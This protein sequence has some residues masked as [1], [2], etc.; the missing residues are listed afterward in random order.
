M[1]GARRWSDPATWGGTRTPQ[2]NEIVVIPAGKA[3]LL[4]VDSPPL[5]GLQIDG[6]LYV[7]DGRDLRL[8]AGWVLVQGLLRAG[9]PQAGHQSRFTLTLTGSDEAVNLRGYGNKFLGV[10][11][12]GLI[13]LHGARRDSLAWAK[14]AAHAAPGDMHIALN[15]APDWR[16]GDELVI[17]PSGYDPREAERV[18]VTAVNGSEVR[19][20]PALRHAHW[21]ELQRYEGRTLDA[22]AAVG[23]LT[24]N[25]VIEGDAASE[26]SQFGG[27]MMVHA[28]GF[29]R[30]TGVSFRRMGQMGH[31]ARYPLHW[32]LVDRRAGDSPVR[33]AGQYA[34]GNSF[35]DSFQRAIVV[36]G[37]N[38]V[39]AERNVAFNVH[40]HIFVPA[41]DGDEENNIFR[42]NLGVLARPPL[43]AY[44]AFAPPQRFLGPMGG[45]TLQMEFQPSVFWSRNVNHSFI[46]NIAAGAAGGHGFLFDSFFRYDPAEPD[47]TFALF[48]HQKP[49]RAIVFEDNVAH[50]IC[51]INT[52]DQP[53][54]WRAPLGRFGN[55]TYAGASASHGLALFS[56][57][58][59]FDLDTSV[60]LQFKRFT[61][62]KACTSGAWIET[63]HERVVDSVFADMPFGLQGDN[64]AQVSE[65]LVIGRS[66]N[67]IGGWPAKSAG[68]VFDDYGNVELFSNSLHNLD[69]GLQ[70]HDSD[71]KM[72]GSVRG[73]RLGEVRIAV[74]ATGISTPGGGSILDEDGTLS[75][76][77]LPTRISVSPLSA[78]SVF[79]PAAR[80]YLT[81]Q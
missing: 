25:L 70:F 48:R 59:R 21:G 79:D 12:G 46:G 33:G 9:L 24:R 8:T 19:F 58:K 6:A 14:L 65:S 3:V 22:R 50:S 60:Q 39:R 75:R 78:R 51:S 16:V 71:F 68:F 10:G 30:V 57:T 41:E 63:A 54:F 80:I 66:A 61:A 52:R 81:P 49:P 47:E 64:I 74:D 4:D 5:A 69:V 20:T 13:D 28:G 26:A 45:Q 11:S 44:G 15:T 67:A 77:G 37:T 31:Q 23:L 62:F 2:A 36:H 43:A 73:M 27:H 29:A 53:D 40:N 38:G 55:L 17:A 76:T 56:A 7:A 32:H 1:D 72:D 18:T 42:F 34:I 35:V